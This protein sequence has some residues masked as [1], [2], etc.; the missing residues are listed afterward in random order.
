MK[1]KILIAD[2][3]ILTLE[4]FK[5][6][7]RNYTNVEPLFINSAK[8]SWQAVKSDPYG[9]AAVVLDFHF[10]EENI[11]GAELAIQMFQKN[12]K[13]PIIICTG[14]ESSAP[15]I[16]S[17]RARV[18]DFVAKDDIDGF[19]RALDKCLLEYDE[20]IRGIGDSNLSVKN[21][22]QENEQFM[23]SLGIIGRSESMRQVCEVID[24]VKD[25][26]AT[27]LVR[28]ESGTGKEV[29]ARALHYSSCRKSNSFIAINCAAI[30]AALLE[31][32]LFGHEKGSF[33]G[34]DSRRI[35]FFEQAHKGTLFLDEIAELPFDLQAKLLRAIEDETFYSVGGKSE[36][37]VDV[38]IIAATNV[39]LKKA[40][41]E[42][43]FREDLYYRLHVVPLELPPLR[44]RPED[45]E[46]LVSCFQKKYRGKTEKRILYRTL[47]NLKSYDW[48]GNV[49]ELENIVESMFV[50]SRT[51]EIGPENLPSYLL[52]SIREPSSDF[53]VSYDVDYPTFKREALSY[54]QQKEN[55]FLITKMGQIR[56]LRKAADFLKIPKTTLLRK[57]SALGYEGADELINKESL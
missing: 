33:T 55:D 23:S 44:D 37:K 16:I 25:D 18:K 38:R 21:R 12:P 24:R 5:Y 48:P 56:S 9:F 28:G 41:Q 19:T 4:T 32:A 20:L 36:I 46:P 6:Q 40:I 14:D 52:S 7:L 27:V 15:A 8:E 13:L 57:L 22:L 45:I 53:T 50:L 26:K 10:E 17:L 51:D 11:N 49:R 54:L 3:N 39:D 47:E 2:D 29:V 31:S 34:A 43:K 35:G 30:P 1:Y 42:K